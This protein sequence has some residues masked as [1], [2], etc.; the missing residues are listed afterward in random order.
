MSNLKAEFNYSIEGEGEG[1]GEGEEEGDG[2]GERRGRGK[3]H[4]R[5]IHTRLLFLHLSPLH[6]LPPPSA[7]IP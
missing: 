7:A 1:E 4:G 2:E 5:L 6:P 3:E